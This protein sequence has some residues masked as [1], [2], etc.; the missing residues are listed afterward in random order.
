MLYAIVL[1]PAKEYDDSTNV[2]M[3]ANMGTAAYMAP[4]LRSAT[5]N[6]VQHGNC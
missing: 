5:V 4:E 6:F 1:P 3:T 2:D